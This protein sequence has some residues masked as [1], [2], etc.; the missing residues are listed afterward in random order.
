M[1]FVNIKLKLYKKLFCGCSLAVAST[2]SGEFM[3][4]LSYVREHPKAQAAVILGLKGLKR[5]GHGF[6][7]SHPTDCESQESK[8][9]SNSLEYIHI[10]N[11]NKINHIRTLKLT[12]IRTLKLTL[13]APIATKVVCFLV[14]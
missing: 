5:R 3:V 9:V 2:G 13:N 10:Y 7:K 8:F 1:V 11:I 6:K 4:L 14:C 12:H